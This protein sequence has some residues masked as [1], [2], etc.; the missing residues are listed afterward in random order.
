MPIIDVDEH[1]FDL[2]EDIHDHRPTMAESSTN[3][4]D[5]IEHL[6]EHTVLIAGGGPV[7]LMVATVLA[8]Y[9]VRSVIL[10]R[11]NSTTK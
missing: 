2:K 10:E 3:G 7:G 11:N 8:H 6:D 5:A 1:S 9:G 4:Q